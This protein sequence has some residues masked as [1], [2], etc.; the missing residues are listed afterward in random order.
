[1]KLKPIF[2][3]IFVEPVTEVATSSK[4][5]IPFKG[6]RDRGRVQN[7]G[8]STLVKEGDLVKYALRGV[9]DLKFGELELHSVDP[10]D[11]E[12]LITMED[13]KMSEIQPLNDRI[14]VR[15][16]EVQ[17]TLASGF[18]LPNLAVEK[19]Q[20]GT[21]L[22]VG[23]GRYAENGTPIPMLIKVGDKVLFPK[24]SGN[25]VHDKDGKE[26]LILKDD[27]VLATVK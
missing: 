17:E 3:R 9:R 4:L 1:M 12:L 19:P 13:G 14:L 2:N 6:F 20:Q 23:T 5:F 25:I 27:E 24:Q 15:V 22:A 7:T 8:G 16:D 18:I 26:L 11:L 10:K 21:V